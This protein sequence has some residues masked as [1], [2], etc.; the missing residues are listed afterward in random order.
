MIKL[1]VA[2]ILGFIAGVFTLSAFALE[3]GNKANR[4]GDEED[5]RDH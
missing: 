2:F 5:D 1:I 4:E 3:A